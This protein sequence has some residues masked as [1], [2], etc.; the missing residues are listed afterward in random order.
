MLTLLRRGFLAAL[1]A[2]PAAAASTEPVRIGY[3]HGGRTNVV[4]RAHVSGFY[5]AEGIPVELYTASLTDRSVYKLPKTLREFQAHKREM[6][7]EFSKMRGTE[8]VDAMMDGKVDAGTIGESSFIQSLAEGKPITAVALLGFDIRAMPGHVI[9]MRRDVPIESPADF[10][11][12]TLVTRRA[13]PGDYIFL[14]EFLADIGLGDDPSI[15]IQAQTPDPEIRPQLE[16][17]EVH[18]GY[19]HLIT[20]FVLRHLLRPYRP[21]NWLNPEMSQAVLVFRNDFLARHPDRVQK[22]VN[23]YLKRIAYEKALPD[24]QVNRTWDKGLA[25]KPVYEGMTIPQYSLPPLL[26]PELLEAMQELLLKYGFIDAQKDLSSAIDNS[27]VRRGMDQV[28]GR[29][30]VSGKYQGHNLLFVSITN[31]G[32]GRMGLY[33]YRRQTTPNIDRWAQG[34]LV[35]DDVFTH[36]S[37]TLPVGVSLFT[38]RYPY[39]HGIFTRSF[40]NSLPGAVLTLPELLREKGYRTAAFTGGLDYDPGFSHMRGFETAP[41]NPSYSGFRVTVPQAQAWLKKN[42]SERFLLFVHGYDAHCPYRPSEPFQGTFHRKPGFKPGINP[43]LCVRGLR[44]EGADYEAEYSGGCPPFMRKNKCPEEM[45]K[46]FRMTQDDVDFL[47]D[48]YDE[49]LLEADALVGGFLRSLPRAVKDKTII[50]VYAEHGEMFAKHGRFGRAGTRRG[51]GYDDVLHVPLIVKFPGAPARRV[52]GLAGIVDLMPTLLEALALP[53]PE[54]M[55]GRSL[56]PLIEDGKPVNEYVYSGAPYNI[57]GLWD[58][59]Y[60][61]WSRS[62]TIRGLRWKLIYEDAVPLAEAGK[63][64]R[65]DGAKESVELYDV[66]ADPEERHD[67]SRVRPQTAAELRGRLRDW[68]R[69]VSSQADVPSTRKIPEEILRQARQRGY[70]QP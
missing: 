27:F 65:A 56:T 42:A 48:S 45:G 19:Y 69:Q 1:L 47:S 30:S 22:V 17:K 7:E 34:A 59:A 68:G 5:D 36:A 50:V 15:K 64:E 49:K 4:F 26:R 63:G 61:Y 21:L 3:F 70:W 66:A 58:K 46:R 13:G 40:K 51:T 16:K 67:L 29:V 10:R 44:M 11:G 35:F 53:A 20:A 32:A 25:M 60:D 52:P 55:Q 33:G 57:Q 24:D 38:S 62:E 43:D 14:K 23:G 6:D 31:I 39:S 8:I 2:S 54:G 41:R 37:W 9:A 28:W 18:G 12:K